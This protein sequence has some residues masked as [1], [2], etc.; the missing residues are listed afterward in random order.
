M[1][2]ASVTTRDVGKKT[3][4]LLLKERGM[5]ARGQ[6]PADVRGSIFAV[7]FYSS[8]IPE[9]D[10]QGALTLLLFLSIGF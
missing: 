3:R 2:G 7:F 10:N 9:R 5:G 6:K 1:D 8:P 4:M